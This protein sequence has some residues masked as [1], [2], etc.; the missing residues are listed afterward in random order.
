MSASAKQI[1]AKNLDSNPT[2]GSKIKQLTYDDIAI[3][4]QKI[5]EEQERKKTKKQHIPVS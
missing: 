5:K 4:Q 3:M 2:K 1:K